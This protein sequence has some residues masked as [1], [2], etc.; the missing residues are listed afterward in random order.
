MSS[1]LRE[2]ALIVFGK[3]FVSN[4]GEIT[5]RKNMKKR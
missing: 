1:F 5:K 2:L 3:G 4:V